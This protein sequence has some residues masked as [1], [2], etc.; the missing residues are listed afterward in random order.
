M[1]ILNDIYTDVGIIWK[2]ETSTKVRNII[3]EFL[4]RR[5]SNKFID[6]ELDKA[7]ND[8]MNFFS[9]HN[10]SPED[11]VDWGDYARCMTAFSPDFFGFD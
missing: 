6:K 10:G 4:E 8:A 9:R 7:Y 1:D 5:Y 11:F 2:E 3:D